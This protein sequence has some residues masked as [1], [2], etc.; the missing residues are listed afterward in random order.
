MFTPR[1][2]SFLRSLARHN[3]REW[4][5]A[6]REDYER[7][8]R[9]PMLAVLARLAQDVPRFSP[10]SIVDP[11]VS[12]Y[13]IY[14]DTRFSEDKSPLKTHIAAL[15]PARGF[16]RHEGAGLYFQ[17]SRTGAWA[18]G[19]LYRPSTQGLQ[20]LR[21]HIA[22]H[23]RQLRTLVTSARFRGVVGELQ[24]ERLTRVPR[25][26]PADH[27]AAEHL[28][29]KQ[30]LASRELPPEDVTGPDFYD[31]L[32]ETFRAVAPLATFLN[33]AMRSGETAWGG[34]DT[35]ADLAGSRRPRRASDA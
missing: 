2:L 35:F 32:L 7:H 21:A 3:D 9:E 12:L 30:F 31:W 6:H 10:E 17:V 29:F 8:V 19:G 5:R 33:T 23:P 15:L 28:R 13:R 18:G 16:G 4:F 27:P 24:G 26:Y 14:R 20:A 25:G 11:K 34:Y 1:T 22:E